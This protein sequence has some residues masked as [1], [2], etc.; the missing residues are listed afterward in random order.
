MGADSNAGDGAIGDDENGSDRVNVV[1]DLRCNDFLAE[2]VS[3][4]IASVSQPRG[5]K[6]ADLRKGLRVLA[7][8]RYV[9]AYQY[10]VVAH[11]LVKMSRVG[12]GLI[13]QIT[14]LIGEV[15]D[16]EVV[17]VRSLAGKDIGDEFQD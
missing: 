9:G 16:S 13:T 5:V 8:F 1:P 3:P 6:D 4:N 11:E 14:L 17:A 2:L 10:T 12:P 15:E 7:T